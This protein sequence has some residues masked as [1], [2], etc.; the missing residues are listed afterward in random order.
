MQQNKRLITIS[1]LSAIA[2]ILTFLKFPLPFL[3]PYLTL[4]FSDVP[5]LL[6]TFIFGPLSGLLVAL[7]KNILNFLFNIGDPVGPVANFLAGASF[8]LTAY[9]VS[10]RKQYSSRRSLI[11]GL[12]AGT[13]AMTIVLSILNYFVLLPLY[14]MIFNLGDVFTNLK[15]IILSGIIPFNIIKGCVI[16]IIFILL[17]RR[18]KKVLK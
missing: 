1:M 13:I 3:P 7:I 2:F 11:I 12:V 4:D 6:A 9:F 10:R 5:T 18:L 14:G 15:V 16:S 8:L 17:Y